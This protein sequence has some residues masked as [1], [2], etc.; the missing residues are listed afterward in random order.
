MAYENFAMDTAARFG[1]IPFA[2]FTSD[3]IS[4][5]FQTLVNSQIEQMQEY[6]SYTQALTS[7][8]STY[9]NN[10][11]DSV[12]M[13][14]IQ[15]LLSNIPLPSDEVTPPVTK[16]YFAVRGTF[17]DIKSCFV[18]GYKVRGFLWT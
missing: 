13:S 6:Q 14:D 12:S 4:S 2:A 5:T 7:S 3:L 17:E 10:T 11:V 15:G 9:I 16:M 8:L 1:E 18:T